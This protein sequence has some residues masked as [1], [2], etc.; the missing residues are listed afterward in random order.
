[1]ARFESYSGTLR[2]RAKHVM[3]PTSLDQLVAAVR[4]H[5]PARAGKLTL[6]ATGNSL[7]NQALGDGTMLV[8]DALPHAITITVDDR[9]S[10]SHD[11]SSVTW[12]TVEVTGWTPWDSVVRASLRLGPPHAW[13]GPHGHGSWRVDRATAG[14]ESS[15]AGNSAVWRAEHLVAHELPRL[16]P[17]T[18]VSSGRITPAGSLSGDGVWRFSAA[19]GRESQSVVWLD[20]LTSD[21]ALVRLFNRR[22]RLGDDQ[23]LPA[24]VATAPDRARNDLWFDAVVGGF[25]LLG[26]IV[27]VKYLLLELD[28]S[29]DWSHFPG[30]NGPGGPP[31]VTR[32]GWFDTRKLLGALT[33]LADKVLLTTL[34]PRW[35]SYPH[36]GAGELG[37]SGAGVPAKAL[38]WMRE[39]SKTEQL[40][41]CL[42]AHW[43]EMRTGAAARDEPRLPP[44]TSGLAYGR[45]GLVFANGTGAPRTILGQIAYGSPPSPSTSFK[46]WDRAYSW[47][48]TARILRWRLLPWA[49]RIGEKI[50][51]DNVFE[52]C[53]QNSP[54]AN[55]IP[56]CG[57]FLEGHAV[58]LSDRVAAPRTLQQAWTIPFE[59]D[60]EGRCTRGKELLVEFVEALGRAS[61]R[62]LWRR[63]A[64]RFQACDIKCL[65]PATALLS[66]SRG[67]ATFMVTVTI[68]NS[69]GYPWLWAGRSSPKR[70]L[71]EI[72]ANFAARGVKVHLTKNLFVTRPVLRGMYGSAFRELL[73]VKRVLDAANK[74]GSE[75]S[76][77][78]AS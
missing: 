3:R 76:K 41:E 63:N 29:V 53:I 57:F 49:A 34:A 48:N 47:K 50:V 19:L 42:A 56:E 70:A 46:L 8:L 52:D 59:V 2:Q 16:V 11:G 44:R 71:E 27:R 10:S 14:G 13:A 31:S 75:F 20:L 64:I 28:T 62:P 43:W 15:S 74:W 65:P 4:R 36:T 5:D 61:R 30:L 39:T 23:P 38:T 77:L 66:S 6:R 25:G 54:T 9:L 32:R 51:Y 22:W 60:A 35:P 78:M 18:F 40:A 26:V 72:T 45:F 67:A 55:P 24:G 73:E 33:T 58:A 69:V 7:H 37:R 1:M 17:Y 12:N 21:G 68:E